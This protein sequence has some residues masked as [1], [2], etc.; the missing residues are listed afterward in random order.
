MQGICSQFRGRLL[1]WSNVL[2][3]SVN[4]SNAAKVNVVTSTTKNSLSNAKENISK[5]RSITAPEALKSKLIA[6]N[7]RAENAD[8]IARSLGSKVSTETERKT[9]EF[10]SKNRKDFKAEVGKRHDG[11]CSRSIIVQEGGEVLKRYSVESLFNMPGGQKQLPIS[12]SD[13]ASKRAPN[14]HDNAGKKKDPEASLVDPVK[15]K[16]NPTPAMNEG[17]YSMKKE[18]RP[19]GPSVK[20]AARSIRQKEITT[21]PQRSAQMSGAESAV[22][23]PGQ[24][25]EE[26]ELMVKASVPVAELEAGQAVS[27]K[28]SS[29]SRKNA[30]LHAAASIERKPAIPAFSLDQTALE[31]NVVQL[32]TRDNNFDSGGKPFDVQKICSST[33]SKE[34][35]SSSKAHTSATNES[36]A[37]DDLL[38]RQL[39][40]RL[41]KLVKPR[42]QPG[43]KSSAHSILSGT[44]RDENAYEV[45]PAAQT[46]ARTASSPN[47]YERSNSFT[48]ANVSE[49][50]V[51]S[52]DKS[53]IPAAKSDD[54]AINF[55]SAIEGKNRLSE[56]ETERFENL[57]LDTL[58]GL[59]RNDNARKLLL[60]VQAP[61]VVASS[62][63]KEG[64]TG[65]SAI[66]SSTQTRVPVTFKDSLPPKI[67]PATVL[68]RKPIVKKS[69]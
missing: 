24:I 28:D 56:K 58:S 31:K 18:A 20:I 17:S 51:L 21:T 65:N 4:P 40:L 45:L 63:K 7:S 26:V 22:I 54:A 3:A 61:K 9:S 10:A 11:N 33:S 5:T 16:A 66:P 67:V 60:A 49:A 32:I 47:K 35:P 8:K 12:T 42:V 1:P 57:S 23:S 14:N 44:K 13:T 50:K 62:S 39:H 48:F 30:A 38:K 6:E 41:N 37:H 34:M 59:G 46:S 29:A 15:Q 25:N 68:L 64:Q 19:V 2:A 55:L 53:F 52:S 69:T 36:S 43:V 27:K